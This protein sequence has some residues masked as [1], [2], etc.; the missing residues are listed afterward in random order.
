MPK[1]SA[2]SLIVALPAPSRSRTARRVGSARAAKARSTVVLG[3]GAGGLGRGRW[4]VRCLLERGLEHL[5]LLRAQVT[6]A[7]EED[8][9]EDAD[10]GDRGPAQNAFTNPSVRAEGTASP[11]ASASSVVETAIVERRAIPRLPICCDVLIKPTPDPPP[12][13]SSRRAPRS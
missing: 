7:H 10:E 9:D 4:G 1:G 5:R 11:V 13:A 12:G 2:S 3:G 6:A 8:R